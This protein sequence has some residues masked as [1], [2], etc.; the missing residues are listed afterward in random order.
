[1]TTTVPTELRQP[2]LMPADLAAWHQAIDAE[3]ARAAWTL[4]ELTW[5]GNAV[6]PCFA[7]VRT[8]DDADLYA[9]STFNGEKNL[10]ARV[11][12]QVFRRTYIGAHT[13]FQRVAIA[14][15]QT[16]RGVWRT[17]TDILTDIRAQ[18]T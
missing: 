10:D 16:G 3:F 14:A 13:Q 6:A 17:P 8:S 9:T 12:M 18:L 4:T 1:M 15:L 5:F 11:V 2:P 7:W